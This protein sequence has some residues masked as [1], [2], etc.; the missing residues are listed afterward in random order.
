FLLAL[1][2]NFLRRYS[3][4]GQASDIE[5]TLGKYL[6]ELT[7][8]DMSLVHYSPS[9][10]AACASFLSRYLI[11][12]QQQQKRGTTITSQIIKK[13]IEYIWP[14]EFF[15]YH[16]SYSFEQLKSGIELLGQLLIQNDDSLSKLKSVKRKYSQACLF[17]IAINDC[18]KAVY[19]Q[20]ALNRLFKE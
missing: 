17:N 8:T 1:A 9:Y 11:L 10:V 18:C 16:T 5:H 13:L 7:F 2:I 15:I 14:T 3:K 20:L 4:I 6:L 12:L 19:I